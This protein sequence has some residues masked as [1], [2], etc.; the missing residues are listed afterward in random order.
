[1]TSYLY[2]EVELSK[3]HEEILGQRTALL[4]QMETLIEGQQNEKKNRT[5]VSEAAHD[6]NTA[7]LKDLEAIEER[8]H[9]RA[10]ILPHPN[11]VSIETQYWASVEEQIPQWEQFLLGKAQSPQ[12]R[13]QRA[14]K[15]FQ[16]CTSQDKQKTKSSDLPPSRSSSK[17]VSRSSTPRAK[18]RS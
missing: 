18:L 5:A 3:R 2:Q 9:A 10:C 15:R 12:G 6:R 8:L 14:G 17:S 4:Q 7:L 16:K 1:M 13:N 11:V